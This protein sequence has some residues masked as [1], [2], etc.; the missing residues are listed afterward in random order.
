MPLGAEWSGG[1]RAAP[2]VREY[3]LVGDPAICGQPWATWGDGS[4]ESSADGD[5]DGDG[6]EGEPP[7]S[8]PP[9]RKDGWERLALDWAEDCQVARTD[10]RWCAE[11]HSTAASFRRAELPEG[12]PPKRAR[13]MPEG[14]GT[15]AAAFQAVA[16]AAKVSAGG[17]WARSDADYFEK[18]DSAFVHDEML[19]DGVRC[20]AYAEAIAACRGVISG[21]VVVDVGAGSGVLSCLCARAGARKVYAIEAS[22]PSAKLCREVVEANGLSGVV[23]VVCGRVEDVSLPEGVRAD[24]IVS[25]WMG[26]FLL[27]ESMLDSVLVARDRWLRPGGL[28][29]PS[30]TRLFLCPFQ[31]TA[32]REHREGLLR[33]VCGLD[34]SAVAPRLCSEE[35]GE[36]AIQGVDPEQLLGEPRC[37]L[38]WDLA[39]L[40]ATE[41]A[42]Q[43]ASLQ[44]SPW[45]G[46]AQPVHGFAGWFDVH[47][48]PPQWSPLDMLRAP[49][50]SARFA[51]AGPGEAPSAAD[52]CGSRPPPRGRLGPGGCVEL[53]TAPGRP[54]T[55]WHQTLFYLPAPLRLEPG[56][57]LAVDVAL[58]RPAESQ[59]YLTVAMAIRAEP[60]E[61]GASGNP[62][63]VSHEWLLRTYAQESL[64]GPPLPVAK[65]RG[66]ARAAAYGGAR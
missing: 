55:C 28:M 40:P 6:A 24:A 27:F 15:Q 34:M 42:S 48:D 38:E 61:P 60:A 62:A 9:Y 44:W 35:S 11:R 58:D 52:A 17:S 18:Y 57:A 30:R 65:V 39:S 2:S 50:L 32:W 1:F 12:P 16:E 59:R 36:P 64:R 29:L 14:S 23:E 22:A 54:R 25:E 53:S 5:E 41:L 63:S 3:V 45:R 56:L 37:V 19:R 46:R 13:G 8:P 4:A 66:T 49:S 51:S 26:F 21:G 31:D 10:E 47:F 43:R 33:S 7:P 20:E